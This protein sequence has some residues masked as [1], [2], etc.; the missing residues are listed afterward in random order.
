LTYNARNFNKESYELNDKLAKSL[1]LDFIKNRGHEIIKTEEDYNFDIETIKNDKKYF[2]ELE[3]KRNYPF[4]S[5]DDYIFNT[6]S[7]LGRKKRLH[8]INPFY[9]IIICKET[10]YALFA[11]SE[12]IFKSEYYQEIN[13]KTEH[14][15]GLDGMYRIPKEYCTFF[16]IG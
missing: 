14:R 8:D 15:N 5:K 13:I 6:V 9:Y 10:Q 1:F 11:Y 2:F 16:Y 3:I 12:D 4:T 7:F